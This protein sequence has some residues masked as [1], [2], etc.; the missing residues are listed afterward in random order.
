MMIS[1]EVVEVV[2]SFLSVSAGITHPQQDGLNVEPNT[3]AHHK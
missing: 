2:L 1:D 3:Y